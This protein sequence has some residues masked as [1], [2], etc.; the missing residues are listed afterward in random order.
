MKAWIKKIKRGMVIR[1]A[2]GLIDIV[3]M[4]G[5][6][7][8]SDK[9]PEKKGRYFIATRNVMLLFWPDEPMPEI[10][11]FADKRDMR[12]INRITNSVKKNKLKK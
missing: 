10:L 9:H 12:R 1:F 8:K 11:G 3:Q 6:F 4:T 2:N 7:G 5:H